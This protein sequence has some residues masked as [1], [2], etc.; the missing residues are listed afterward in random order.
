MDLENIHTQGACPYFSAY[1][2]MLKRAEVSVTKQMKS[3]YNSASDD[4][5]S[6]KS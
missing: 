5:I 3:S 4:E 1:Q 6:G 2:A